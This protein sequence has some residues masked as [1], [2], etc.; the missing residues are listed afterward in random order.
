MT[1]SD[2]ADIFTVGRPC[3]VRKKPKIS[4]QT[5]KPFRRYK[6]YKCHQ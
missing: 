4:A 5:I 1:I 6:R 3:Q 2:L